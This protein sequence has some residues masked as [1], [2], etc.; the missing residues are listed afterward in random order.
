[1]EGAKGRPVLYQGCAI[2]EGMVRKLRKRVEKAQ[3]TGQ[4]K[5]LGEG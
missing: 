1:M 5:A 4:R 2:Y 3:G